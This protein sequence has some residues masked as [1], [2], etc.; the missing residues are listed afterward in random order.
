[1]PYNKDMFKPHHIAL[2][3]SNKQQ[4]CSFYEKLGFHIVYTWEADDKSLSITHL[5]NNN[6]ILELFC[7]QNPIPAPDTIFQ[8]STDL[9]ILGTKHFGLQVESIEDARIYLASIGVID[10]SAKITDGKTEVRYFFI[11]DPDDI[12][13]EILEDKRGI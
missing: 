7:Y 6:L 4:S 10:K 3:I 11:K 5:S 2:S 12:L 9:P 13:V 8:T 1:M